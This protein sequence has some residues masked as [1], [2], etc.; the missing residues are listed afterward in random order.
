[1]TVLNIQQRLKNIY[2]TR[3]GLHCNE[4]NIETIKF[5]IKSESQ[6]ADIVVIF[7]E[8]YHLAMVWN[9]K[10]RREN[11]C[12]QTNLSYSKSWSGMV[13]D[14]HEI[15]TYYKQLNSPAGRIYEK[16]IVLDFDTLFELSDCLMGLLDFD[17]NDNNY[18]T[19]NPSHTQQIIDEQKN[20]G[21]ITTSRWNRKQQFRKE[22]LTAYNFQCAI[23]RCNEQKLLQ[24]AHIIAVSDGGNDGVLNGICLCANHHLMLDNELIAIDY[25]NL[26]LS[27]VADSVKDMPWYEEF[28]TKHQ[29]KLLKQQVSTIGN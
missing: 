8:T 1:M 27:Y 13:V 28:V 29:E 12:F 23:C 5:D 26:C 22:V 18:C 19:N 24:A 21:R 17:P 11:Q 7:N 9:I 10:L 15:Q 3:I 14:N 25:D 2:G 6:T 16:I 20:R 4:S